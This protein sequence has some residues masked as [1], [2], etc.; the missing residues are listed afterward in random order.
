MVTEIVRLRG[1]WHEPVPDEADQ[2]EPVVTLVNSDEVGPLGELVFVDL[3]LSL[4]FLEH[5]LQIGRLRHVSLVLLEF[6][7]VRAVILKHFLIQRFLV[8]AVKLGIRGLLEGLQADGALAFNRVVLL[9]QLLSDLLMQVK[10]QSAVI[11]LL[12]LLLRN[13]EHLLVQ[14]LDY[15]FELFLIEALA[16]NELETGSL[17][18]VTILEGNLE[19]RQQAILGFVDAD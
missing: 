6:F 18:R 15:V 12:S 11:V 4:V 7:V 1:A 5:R 13:R 3:R 8:G 16:H 14:M 9:R 2:V 10:K 19:V 17:E